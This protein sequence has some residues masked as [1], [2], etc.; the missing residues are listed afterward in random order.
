MQATLIVSRHG[1]NLFVTGL[2]GT[3]GAVQIVPSFYRSDFVIG[4]G[5]FIDAEPYGRWG[6]RVHVRR[7]D[8]LRSLR[9]IT[10]RRST[11]RVRVDVTRRGGA[12]C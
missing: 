1:D 6:V 7:L 8:T 10:S 12:A 3:H 4:R 5:R 2:A 9:C 11:A